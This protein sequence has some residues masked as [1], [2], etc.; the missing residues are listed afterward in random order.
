MERIPE[1]PQTGFKSLSELLGNIREKPFND[2]YKIAKDEF[3]RS[4]GR[5]DWIRK[6]HKVRV[7]AAIDPAASDY[8]ADLKLLLHAMDGYGI[9]PIQGEH[10]QRLVEEAMRKWRP[11]TTPIP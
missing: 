5:M 8:F 2:A 9:A 3:V 1:S 7:V 4:S 6:A 10:S 11:P